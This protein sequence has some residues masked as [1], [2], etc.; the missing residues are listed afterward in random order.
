MKDL[1][2]LKYLLEENN[3]LWKIDLKDVYFSVLLCMTSTK[4][5]R[6]PWLKNLN[7]FPCLRFGLG[8]VSNILSKLLMI[9]IALLKWLNIRLAIY[10]DVIF[11]DGKN[12][13]GNFNKQIHFD[14]SV[15]ASE[16][17]HKS[18]KISSETVPPN[19]N[20]RPK[21]RYPHHELGTNIEKDGKGDF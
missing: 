12:V 13:R 2:C 1:Y 21:T 15:S 9:P 10:L 18:E 17:C 20:F 3:F 16:F 6:F 7:A 19:R 4:F 11:S 8:S 5:G 14:F